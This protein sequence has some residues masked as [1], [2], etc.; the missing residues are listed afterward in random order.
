M[1]ESVRKLSHQFGPVAVQAA[2]GLYKS[3][4]PQMAAA[5]AYRTIFALVPVIIIGLVV[6]RLLI[7]D[8]TEL[9]N[10]MNS[11]V[12]FL[13]LRPLVEVDSGASRKTLDLIPEDRAARTFSFMS[14]PGEV[15]Y[16]PGAELLETQ[17]TEP[18]NAELSQTS[19]D[20]VIDGILAHFAKIPFGAIGGFGVLLLVYAAISMLVELER[21]FN[22]IYHAQRGR[23]WVRRVTQYWSVLTLGVIFLVASFYVGQTFTNLLNSFAAEDGVFSRQ[24]FA[25]GLL[26]YLTTVA[27]SSAL[28]LFTYKTIPNVR[29][30][31]GPAVIGAVVAA[32]LWEAGKWGFTRYLSFS[33]SYQYIYGSIAI[34][35]L[36]ILWVYLTWLVVLFGLQVS[37]GLQY[38][39]SSRS[40]VSD[41]QS[42]PSVV[43]AS[44]SI[45]LAVLL[46]ER[47]EVGNAVDAEEAAQRLSMPN[48]VC[49]LMLERFERAELVRRVETRD[50]D[51]DPSWVLARPA[52]KVLIA[53]VL[54]STTD[55]TSNEGTLPDSVLPASTRIMRSMRDAI[56]GK[57]IADCL[58]REEVPRD[59]QPT[60]A[61]QPGGEP[62][63]A[64]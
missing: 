32:V 52:G 51:D 47:F 49:T 16:E 36:F 3:R 19:I 48:D 24:G 59:T 27:I 35:P 50:A 34:V 20:S 54:S 55:S 10:R 58:H 60:A 14:P 46:A 37:Y 4:L 2:R 15:S 11:A 41:N 45:D 38:A 28:L 21:A 44:R 42:G 30:P 5:L 7:V 57:T 23:S 9:R 40:S 6:L 63:P 22:Q 61:S 56:A 29:V 18:E 43:D 62:V 26:G 1:L 53:D 17:G 39:S 25:F 13:G 12:D 31:F 8:E 33:T 64:S